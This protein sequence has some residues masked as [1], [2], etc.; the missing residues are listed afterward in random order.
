MVLS[1]RI[2]FDAD[3]MTFNTVKRKVAVMNLLLNVTLFRTKKYKPA[4][5]LLSDVNNASIDTWYT[6][7]INK[8]ITVIIHPA[9]NEENFLIVEE[10]D[11]EVTAKTGH[12]K[13][14]KR[15]EKWLPKELK[16]VTNNTTCKREYFK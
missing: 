10:Y 14:V 7:L 11:D 13:W 15:F 1:V 16:D 3:K 5:Y 2:I 6:K 9:F 8:Y 4:F 12:E